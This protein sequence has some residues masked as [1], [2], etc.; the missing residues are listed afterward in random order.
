MPL[1][2]SVNFFSDINSLVYFIFTLLFYFIFFFKLAVILTLKDR[3]PIRTLSDQ[4]GGALRA[5]PSISETIVD[6]N[7]KKFLVGHVYI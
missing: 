7:L 1:E 4:G 2:R 5:P 3:A 6:R